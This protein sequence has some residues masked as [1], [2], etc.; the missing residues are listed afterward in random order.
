MDELIAHAPHDGPAFTEDNAT[1][2]RL[3]HDMLADTSHMLSMKTFQRTRY[4]RGAFQAIQRHNMG[5]SKWDKV[6][7]D[8]ESMVQ[9]IVRN[10]NNSRFPL[11]VHIN[12]HR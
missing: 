7:E 8:T 12:K 10:G 11:K 6:L 5:E 2:L 9:K 3:L 4:G 1:V